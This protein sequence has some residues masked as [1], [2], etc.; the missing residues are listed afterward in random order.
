MPFKVYKPGE[1]KGNK[2]CVIRI[3]AF[4]RVFE[5]TT[6]TTNPAV[7]RRLG[8]EAEARLRAAGPDAP[9]DKI[10]FKQAADL[11]RAFRKPRKIEEQRIA[12]VV[13][14][15]GQHWVDELRHADLVAAANRALPGRG[16]ATRNRNFM[17]PAA[18]I[19]HYAAKNEYCAWMRV[20]MFEEPK[21]ATRAVRPEAMEA[22][23][24]A[25]D[26]QKQLLLLWLLH[27]GTR[28]THTLSVT[29]EEGIDLDPSVFQIYNTKGKCWQE[30][31]IHEAVLECLR[32]VPVEKR[33][34]RLFS[35]GTGTTSTAGF[36]RCGKR[37]G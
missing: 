7:A 5:K 11:Y 13:A 26:E 36:A 29:W 18:S 16:P 3:T 14:Q 25:T 28:I 21:A 4:G 31:P 6:D 9:G 34:G 30:F 17:R 12:G 20:Q 23:I 27:H 10:T 15:L 37:S 2:T 35:W 24:E 19:L 1:R 22:L 8:I 32:A 33:V